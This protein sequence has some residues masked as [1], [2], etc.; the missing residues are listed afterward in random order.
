MQEVGR[1]IGM[2]NRH[3]KWYSALIMPLLLL[4]AC[5]EGSGGPNPTPTPTATP[6]PSPTPTS[7][8]TPTP[9]PTPTS[10]SVER[11]VLP[12]T[13]SSAITTD[14]EPHIAIT[15]AAGV[16]R[17]RLFVMLPGTNSAPDPY[18]LIIRRGA[19]RGF[20]TVGLNYPNVEAVAELCLLNGDTNCSG[21]VRRETITGTDSSTLVSVNPANS[22]TGRLTSLLSYMAATYPNEG[23]G[24]Y[25]TNGRP[26]WALITMAGHS[27]GAGHAGY[28]AKL[29]SLDRVVMFAGPA[30]PAT[31][32]GQL[33]AWLSTPNVTPVSRQYGFGHTADPL[34]R[35]TSLTANW[36]AMGLNTLGGTVSVD[37][38][39]APYSNSRQLLTS[40][41]STSAHS[42]MVVDVFTPL[43]ASGQ[44]IYR[45][46]WDYMAFP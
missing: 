32:S 39:P 31:A 43:D 21:N 44:P 26:N 18:K 15:P 22:I 2:N 17:G 34:V 45:L 35:L 7:T 3:N 27:Q 20:H 10:A 33:A 40:A 29:E 8:P 12:R 19:Q 36:N 24:Q 16:A 11:E 13:T 1:S 14:L 23:W 41:S 30:E 5:G 25:L 42:S 28:L 9:T 37:S 38:V 4:S 6:A 46:V